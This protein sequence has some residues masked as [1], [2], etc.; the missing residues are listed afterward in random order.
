MADNINLTNLIT[1]T[2]WKSGGP[3]FTSVKGPDWGLPATTQ[4]NSY[5]KSY[6]CIYDSKSKKPIC[7]ARPTGEFNS[8]LDCRT[9]CYM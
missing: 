3:I 5:S 8:L 9:E 2:N 6:N 4:I 7:M 1:L